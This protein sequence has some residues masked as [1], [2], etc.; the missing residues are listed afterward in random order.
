MKIVWINQ[1]NTLRLFTFTE[2]EEPVK[3]YVETMV[4]RTFGTGDA[5]KLGK[6]I[7]EGQ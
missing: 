3:R 1:T 2:D 5:M 4:R 6:P 7:P